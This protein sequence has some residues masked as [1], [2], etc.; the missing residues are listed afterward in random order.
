MNEHAFTIDGV[1]RDLSTVWAHFQ[2]PDRRTKSK[3]FALTFSLDLIRVK[4][5][6][7]GRGSELTPESVLHAMQEAFDVFGSG[8]MTHLIKDILK[9][10]K[11]KPKPY[12]WV[13]ATV[14]KIETVS[15]DMKFTGRIVPFAP[16]LY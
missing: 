3:P 11:I 14:D 5:V 16:H 13:I 4:L 12:E 7:A 9:S 10:E 8:E 1:R 6:R 2:D 15:D